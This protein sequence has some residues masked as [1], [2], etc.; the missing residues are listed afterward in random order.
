MPRGLCDSYD[1]VIRL[2]EGNVLRLAAHYGP[3]EPGFGLERPLRRCTGQGHPRAA[4][5]FKFQ[6]LAEA[7]DFPDANREAAC[8]YSNFLATPLLREGTAIGVISIRRT[9]IT[10]FHRQADRTA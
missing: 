5:R 3:V 6:T 1:A 4:R 8:G 9:E 2:L 10:P 7:E